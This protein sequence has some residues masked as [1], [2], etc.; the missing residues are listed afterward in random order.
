MENA[1]QSQHGYLSARHWSAPPNIM[2]PSHILNWK[3]GWCSLAA[4]RGRYDPTSCTARSAEAGCKQTG[5]VTIEQ[6]DICFMNSKLY[7][8][9]ICE[10]FY[11]GW[12]IREARTALHHPRVSPPV[13]SAGLSCSTA[14]L[15]AL[16]FPPSLLLPLTESPQRL[17][18]PP[19]PLAGHPLL[20][21]I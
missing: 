13:R 3:K 15:T 11:S 4:L 16:S 6:R 14:S 18:P 2:C 12:A 20:Q 19:G 10:T 17:P 5:H 8:V 1:N 21:N 9:T 7:C